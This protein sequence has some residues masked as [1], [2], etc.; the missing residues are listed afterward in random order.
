MSNIHL[1][2][3][4][5]S[6]SPKE[7]RVIEDHISSISALSG[8]PDESKQLKYFRHVLESKG[9]EINPK[10][11]SSVGSSN[12]S[13]LKYHLSE[14]IYDGLLL[15]KH[16]QNE[17]LF[18]EREQVLFSLKKKILLI[19]ILYRTLNQGR[20]ETIDI[21][22]QETIKEARENE[23]YD[24]LAEALT[25]QKY[26]KSIRLG[27]QE[28]EKLTVEADNA[29]SCERAVQNANDF[30]YRLIIDNSF[31]KSLSKLE[32][33][34]HIDNSIKQMEHDYNKYKCQEVNYYL[35]IMQIV[36]FERQKNYLKSIE[37]CNKLVAFL[38]KSTIVNSKVRLGF[39]SNNLSQYKTFIGKY[40]EAIKDSQNAQKYFI[41]NSFNF[42]SSK[43]QEFY[44]YFY[45]GYYDKAKKCN[46]DLIDHS[47]SDV[48][49]FRKSKF[50]YYQA[51]ILFSE[52]EFKEALGLLSKSQE[53]EKDK[54]RWN[55][56][57]RILI[58]LTFIELSKINEAS[59]ALESLRK[60]I[61]RASKESEVS[62]RDK[63]IVKLLRIM[64]KD[65]FEY[66]YNNPNINSLHKTLSEK[67]KPVSWEHYSSE[68]IPFNAWL[69]NRK[70]SR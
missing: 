11:I 25:I 23:I 3:F 6:L 20:T 53:I 52:G 37:H 59:N 41:T 45:G 19:K 35:H 70:K 13:S 12:L 51:C 49:Q 63:L 50:V 62:E 22:L 68:L 61:E 2:R 31:I 66:V 21:L 28:F 40:D 55:I 17:E 4:I 43:E 44:A 14:K 15:S 18:S 65:G 16:I 10:E 1:D 32:L 38:K 39:A 7:I 57:L 42:L 58:I 36:K 5:Q 46:D 34:K 67:N 29:Y 47:L 69:E 9:K 8:N 64:E 27:K 54:A 30:Y 26:F 33:D 60:Y 48:G 24:V 56:S